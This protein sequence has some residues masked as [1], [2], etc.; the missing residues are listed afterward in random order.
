[1]RGDEAQGTGM[2]WRVSVGAG[3]MWASPFG[4]IR[5][6]YAE[7]IVKEDFDKVQQ[8]RFSMSNQF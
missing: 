4:N 1:M 2:S 5:F 8:F 3:I 6:D 7:P